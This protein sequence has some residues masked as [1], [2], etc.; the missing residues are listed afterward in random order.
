MI[1][2][3]YP[4]YKL[5][6]KDKCSL[7]GLVGADVVIQKKYKDEDTFSITSDDGNIYIGN[8][9]ELVKG[10]NLQFNIDENFFHESDNLIYYG[11]LLPKSIVLWDAWDKYNKCFVNTTCITK[12]KA[13]VYYKGKFSLELLEIYNNSI[14]RFVS[15]RL[16]WYV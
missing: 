5:Y 16:T 2:R 4:Y 14:Y 10:N 8:K 12:Y 1:I 3:N 9:S 7:A 6:K 15:P 11:T 13:K